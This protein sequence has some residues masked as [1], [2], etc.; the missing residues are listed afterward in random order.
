VAGVLGVDGQVWSIQIDG[1]TLSR[2]RTDT[3][4][5]SVRNIRVKG[6]AGLPGFARITIGADGLLA[7]PVVNSKGVWGVA[8]RAVDGAGGWKTVKV[9][10]SRVPMAPASGMSDLIAGPD[11]GLWFATSGWIGHITASGA[12]RGYKIPTGKL[13]YPESRAPHLAVGADGR[14]YFTSFNGVGSISLKG[15]F[16]RWQRV[17]AADVNI[18]LSM[19]TR[20]GDEHLWVTGGDND[21]LLYRNEKDGTWSNNGHFWESVGDGASTWEGLAPDPLGGVLELDGIKSESIDYDDPQIRQETLARVRVRGGEL[22]PPWVWRRSGSPTPGVPLQSIAIGPADFPGVEGMPSPGRYAIVT[23][24]DGRIWVSQLMWHGW[25]SYNYQYG[26][27]VPSPK[28]RARVL[29]VWR[30]GRTVLVR[31]G[32]VGQTAGWCQGTVKTT[33]HGHSK[34]VSY[35]VPAAPAKVKSASTARVRLSSQQTG[36]VSKGRRVTVK[37]LGKTWRVK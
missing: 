36:D 26:M 21:D 28:G 1:S 23:L 17:T 31:I 37:T 30:E 9:L 29:R 35:T 8:R 24:P 33:V 6:Q 20:G 15:K 12:V 11:G 3:S 25:E 19:I 18:R 4:K 32:C 13:G 10:R 14:V 16:G 2:V 22:T 27:R 7:V 34:S 5:P